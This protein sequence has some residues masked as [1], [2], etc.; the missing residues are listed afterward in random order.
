MSTGQ[1]PKRRETDE[2][3]ERRAG[4]IADR[5][6][7]QMGQPALTNRSERRRFMRHLPRELREQVRRQSGS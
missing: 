5:A 6:L 2:Q 1:S 4:K 3:Q 7:R